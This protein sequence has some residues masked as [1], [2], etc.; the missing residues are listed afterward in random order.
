TPQTHR[1][2]AVTLS[3]QAINA[4]LEAQIGVGTGE[5]GSHPTRN[6]PVRPPHILWRPAHRRLPRQYRKVRP[7]CLRLHPMIGNL[8]TPPA[9]HRADVDLSAAVQT[10][11]R[12]AA[13]L[14]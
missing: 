2:R 3:P 5:W 12:C 6:A 7:P 11:F 1:K 10:F 8:C 14:P 4:A 13:A 9:D